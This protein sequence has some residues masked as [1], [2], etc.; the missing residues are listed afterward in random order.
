[1]TA[2]I[3]CATIILGNFP[4]LVKIALI[5]ELTDPSPNLMI[6]NQITR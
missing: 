1:M 2:V 5:K 6:F 4:N 3:E